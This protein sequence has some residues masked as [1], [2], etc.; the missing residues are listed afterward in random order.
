MPSVE[1]VAA[2]DGVAGVSRWTGAGSHMV[3]HLTERY[4]HINTV[5]VNSAAAAVQHGST[6]SLSLSTLQQVTHP[7]VGVVATGPYAGVPAVVVAAGEV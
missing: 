3:D 4:Q 1:A 2:G 5:T 7:A 6:L